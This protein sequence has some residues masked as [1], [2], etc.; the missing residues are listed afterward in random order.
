[1]ALPPPTYAATPAPLPPS[2][3]VGASRKALSGMTFV[4]T[5][6]FPEFGGDNGI[7]L[8]KERVSALIKSHGA[9]VCGSVSKKTTALLVGKDPGAGKVR[10]AGMRDVVMINLKGLLQ[11]ISGR[12]VS[13]A[14]CPDIGSFSTGYDGSVVVPDREAQ[15][16]RS[17]AKRSKHA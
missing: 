11:V 5:G 1:M 2:P 6:T 17:E 15:F 4:L 8:G 14:D 10:E 9:R 12:P 7:N 3:S 13:E 16:L